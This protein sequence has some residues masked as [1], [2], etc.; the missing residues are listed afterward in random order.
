M[1]LAFD[2]ENFSCCI[3]VGI[4]KRRM[5]GSTFLGYI[6]RSFPLGLFGKDPFA[7]L[8]EFSA[9]S[10]G[11]LHPCLQSAAKYPKSFEADPMVC[12]IL[13]KLLLLW[14]ISGVHLWCASCTQQGQWHL[15][16]LL[17]RSLL[18]D[19]FSFPAFPLAGDKPITDSVY[20]HR[21]HIFFPKH[22]TVILAP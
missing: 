5:F 2:T 13:I 3:L 4:T 19:F 21:W 6:S 20:L 8:I 16:T 11:T 22:V 17:I 1:A 18:Q 9:I 14:V 12:S 15:A 7:P 10:S